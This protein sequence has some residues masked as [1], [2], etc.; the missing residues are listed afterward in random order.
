MSVATSPM[1]NQL[2]HMAFAIAVLLLLLPVIS[3]EDGAEA[4]EPRHVHLSLGRDQNATHVSMTVSF[5]VLPGCTRSLS[6]GHDRDMI[7]GAVQHSYDSREWTD[8]AFVAAEDVQYYNASLTEHQK[9]KTGLSTYHSDLY[10]HA[11]LSGLRPS[12]KVFYRCVLVVLGDEP[13]ADV[14]HASYLRASE[15]LSTLQFES[16]IKAKSER[17]FFLSPPSVGQWYDPPLDRSIRFAVIGDLATRPHSRKTISHFDQDRRETNSRGRYRHYGRGVDLLLL[18]GDLSY[19][20]GDQVIWDDWFDM[21]SEFSFFREI[22]TSIAL[23][24]HDCDHGMFGQVA[25]DNSSLEIATAY[26]KRFRM[27]QAKAAQRDLAP[28]ELFNLGQSGEYFQAKDFLP[29]E[30]GNAYYSYVFGPSKHIV[31]SSYSSFLP[32]SIQYDWLVRELED[33]DRS[34]TPWLI[35]MLHCPPYTTFKI[36]HNEVFI[37]EA[38][39]HLEPLFVRH[40]VN[41]VLSG[42][43]HSYMR[44]APTIDSRPSPRGPVYIIQG[45]GGRQANEP[46]LAEE[47]EEF[48]SVRDHSMYGYGTLDLLNNTHAKWTWVITGWNTPDDSGLKGIYEPDFDIHDEVYLRNQLYVESATDNVNAD[49]GTS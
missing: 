37:S 12:T 44:T 14:T 39:R 46:Y 4:C 41:F 10:F 29:Y 11:E 42:H 13:A 24:N 47:P 27:P 15:P 16:Q 5:G 7:F 9:K 2:R 31:I 25:S 22:P 40:T 6:K 28:N 35:V 21:M 30:F 26:E 38:R 36:H 23:G 48:V 8:V 20:N 32:G 33:T 18:A 45:N 17:Y 3:L 19:A 1:I 34:V 49:E 43:L